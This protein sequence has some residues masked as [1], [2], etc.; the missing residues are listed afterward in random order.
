MEEVLQEPRPT[1]I[2]SARLAVIQAEEAWRAGLRRRLDMQPNDP[3]RQQI[4][5]ACITLGERKAVAIARLEKLEAAD[6]IPW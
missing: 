1:E 4:T 5:K 3:N 6:D 2:A